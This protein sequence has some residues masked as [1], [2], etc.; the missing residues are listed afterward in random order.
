MV[1]FVSWLW[2]VLGIALGAGVT[3]L[4]LANRIRKPLENKARDLKDTKDN[5]NQLL[6]RLSAILESTEEPLIA[7]NQKNEVIIFNNA[8]VRL[9]G[10]PAKKTM[11]NSVNTLLRF[12]NK[13]MKLLNIKETPLFDAFNSLKTVS[14]NIDDHLF[15]TGQQG[16]RIPVAL[17]A[18]PV[19]GNHQQVLGAVCVLRD[20]SV[21][22]RL[23]ELQNE[24]VFVAAHEL[25]NPVSAI[26]GYLEMAYEAKSNSKKLEMALSA[27]GQANLRLTKLI[28]DLLQVA[29]FEADRLKPD[30][31]KVSVSQLLNQVLSE[32][33]KAIMDK[34]LQLVYRPS[35][36]EREARVYAD[37]DF[38]MEVLENLIGNAIKFTVNGSVKISH[39]FSTKADKL[40]VERKKQEAKFLITV[41][42]DTGIG[43]PKDEQKKVF[44]KF[45]RGSN[46]K[47]EMVGN[48]LG[49]FIIKQLVEK[50]GGKIWF[51]S[52]DG[53]GCTFYFSVPL[54]YE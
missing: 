15:I 37:K 50:M 18:S 45:F 33:N 21:E 38:L 26:A 43:I 53:K 1:N 2:G 3:G 19:I 6:H 22:K 34:G 8:A 36:I 39:N 27:I 5:L 28:N 12:R 20:V 24:F 14:K 7:V 32:N 51:E 49:N 23:R 13:Q 35:K 29:R 40:G 46:L 31:V 4:L 9:T 10:Y 47:R 44:E 30:L 16:N 54:N 42:K 48:G 17:T 41:V 11:G 25:K 52:I